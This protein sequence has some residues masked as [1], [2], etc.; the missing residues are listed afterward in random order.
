MGDCRLPIVD[1]QTVVKP[2]IKGLTPFGERLGIQTEHAG[3][4]LLLLR[5]AFCILPFDLPSRGDPLTRPAPA[6]E[7]AGCGPPSPPRG[8]G[9]RLRFAGREM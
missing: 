1:W 4:G 2:E 9:R 3:R 8:R 6:D 5:F 7:N